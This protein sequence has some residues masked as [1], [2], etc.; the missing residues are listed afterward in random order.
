MLRPADRELSAQLIAQLV[1]VQ[2]TVT[3]QAQY[4]Q[5]GEDSLWVL[6]H[7]S[8]YIAHALA[9]L[10]YGGEC[11]PPQ[12][13]SGKTILHPSTCTRPGGVGTWMSVTRSVVHG[14]TP[15]GRSFP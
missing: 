8:E 3:N 6:A 11:V 2:A 10:A 5:E 9:I 12:L 1:T 7:M 13:H 15:G 14:P 4:W